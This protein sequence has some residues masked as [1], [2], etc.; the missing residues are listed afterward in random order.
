[1][2]VYHIEVVLHHNCDANATFF[3]RAIK[4]YVAMLSCM[5]VV[6]TALML[7]VHGGKAG[8]QDRLQYG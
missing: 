2:C 4:N 6:S 5:Y 8:L 1:M 3:S 7:T